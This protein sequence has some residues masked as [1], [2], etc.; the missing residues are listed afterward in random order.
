MN[1][2]SKFTD[3]SPV[4]KITDTV[5]VKWI[6]PDFFKDFTR[7]DGT[8]CIEGITVYLRRIRA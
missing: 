3:L 6:Y 8:V 1:F 2:I 5:L 4:I 7:N